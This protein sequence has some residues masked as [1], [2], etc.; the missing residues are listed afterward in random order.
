MRPPRRSLR[1]L[2]IT[3]CDCGGGVVVV[4]VGVVV[5]VVWLFAGGVGVGGEGT[6]VGL[7]STEEL[8]HRLRTQDMFVCLFV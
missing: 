7:S 3:C 1:L 6:A 2:G 8:S 5:V 4:V